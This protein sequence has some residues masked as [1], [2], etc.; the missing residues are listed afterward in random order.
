MRRKRFACSVVLTLFAACDDRRPTAPAI[1]ASTGATSASVDVRLAVASSKP[2]RTTRSVIAIRGL[3]KKIAGLER[4][5]KHFPKQV[6]NKPALIG[7]LSSRASALGR[8]SDL[9]RMVELADELAKEPVNQRN[10]LAR[11]KAYGHVHRFAKALALLDQLDAMQKRPSAA[12]REARGVVLMA[13][14]KYREAFVR[15]RQDGKPPHTSKLGLEAMVL[16]R[17]GRYREAD[18]KFMAAERAYRDVSPFVFAWLYFQRASMWDRAGDGEKAERYYRRA[19]HHLPEHAHAVSHLT[20]FVSPS[21]AE[22]LLEAVVKTSDDPEYR[23]ALGALKNAREPKS[24]DALIE[25]AKRGYDALMAK[26]PLAFADHAGWFYLGVGRDPHRAVEVA[27][28]NLSARHTPE[29]FELKIASLLAVGEHDEACET[30]HEA[31]AAPFLPLAL[32]AACAGAFEACGQT[33]QAAELRQ[34]AK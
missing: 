24:G 8:V 27:S 21:E 19:V 31:I 18:E 11:A 17:L 28:M 33:L 5:L 34:A 10:L 9:D 12:T 13:L 7:W 6:L 29:A 22:R 32:G 16:G 30:A 23:A 15:L 3:D 4:R 25:E 2:Q 20:S 14:G 1:D 26:H